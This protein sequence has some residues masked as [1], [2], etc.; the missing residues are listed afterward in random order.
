M[1]LALSSTFWALMAQEGSFSTLFVKGEIQQE[2]GRASDNLTIELVENFTHVP[3]GRQPVMQDGSFE[4][5]NVRPGEYELRI[6]GAYGDLIHKEIVSIHNEGVPLE[7]KLPQR[8]TTSPISGT[9]SAAALRR[10]VSAQAVREMVRSERKMRNGDIQ[11]SIAHLKKAIRIQPDY[12]EAYNNLGTRYMALQDYERAIAQ[13]REALRLDCDA[14]LAH[15]NLGLAM[16]ILKD[17]PEAE[18][19]LRSAVRLDG[20]SAKAH[21]LLGLVLNLQRRD[22]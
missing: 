5:H 20:S 21:Y 10:H 22:P 3:A 7:V 12:M 19:E 13:F 11:S 4:F 16:F 15:T 14:V 1:L 17:L 9:I 6:N 18:A 8:R 2:G